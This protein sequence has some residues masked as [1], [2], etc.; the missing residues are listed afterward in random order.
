MASDNLTLLIVWL[1]WKLDP[2]PDVLPTITSGMHT[3]SV[4]LSWVIWMLCCQHKLCLSRICEVYIR[5]YCPTF[6]QHHKQP[7]DHTTCLAQSV[8]LFGCCH[9]YETY[10]IPSGQQVPFVD[11]TLL[12]QS[13]CSYQIIFTTSTLYI[14]VHSFPFYYCEFHF[15]CV[16]CDTC[17]SLFKLLH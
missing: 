7:V 16:K 1:W 9:S 11:I 4:T 12:K 15:N 17:C 10:I 2:R 5:W 3:D 8:V 6:Q 13:S 14:S